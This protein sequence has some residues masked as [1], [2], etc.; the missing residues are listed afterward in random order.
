MLATEAARVRAR[1]LASGGKGKCEGGR[2]GGGGT[3]GGTGG[4]GGVVKGGVDLSGIRIERLGEESALWRVY[5]GE[6]GL[7]PSW[8]E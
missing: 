1:K 4:G 8:L 3:E 6:S 5:W 2:Y 7:P